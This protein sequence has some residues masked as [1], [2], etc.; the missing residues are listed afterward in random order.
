MSWFATMQADPGR[1][2]TELHWRATHDLADM[3]TSTWN[4]QSQNP[5]GYDGDDT[6]H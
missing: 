6:G 3:A 5:D 1:A 4:W 2:A